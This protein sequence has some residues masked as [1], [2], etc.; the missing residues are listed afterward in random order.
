MLPTPTPP[1]P[2]PLSSPLRCPQICR[3]LSLLPPCPPP[4]L[5]C[6]IL[7]GFLHPGMDLDASGLTAETPGPAGYNWGCGSSWGSP[8]G[9]GEQS[10]PF[11]AG[12]A[13]PSVLPLCT[14]TPHLQPTVPVGAW[15]LRARAGQEDSR[16]VS[17]WPTPGKVVHRNPASL[18][19]PLAVG[20]GIVLISCLARAPDRWPCG[21]SASGLGQEQRP[22]NLT[23]LLCRQGS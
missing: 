7:L 6:L 17:R 15:L 1:V 11:C 12:A 19:R 16:E 9:W 23:S 2:L 10:R 5:F 20:I 13:P 8:W 14:P 21:V 4:P 3:S 18:P 22:S